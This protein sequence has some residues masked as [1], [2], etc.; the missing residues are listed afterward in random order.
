MHHEFGRHR[1]WNCPLHSHLKRFSS[2]PEATSSNSPPSTNLGNVRSLKTNAFKRTGPCA[3]YL[4]FI[5]QLESLDRDR[6]KQGKTVQG[7]TLI[8]GVKP[9]V[10]WSL[11]NFAAFGT[12]RKPSSSAT[13]LLSAVTRIVASH[14]RKQDTP[15]S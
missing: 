2:F 10:K 9:S 5:R 14:L 8:F 1:Q 12:T 4:L 6:V 13:I 11:F 7:Q 3:T 15:D